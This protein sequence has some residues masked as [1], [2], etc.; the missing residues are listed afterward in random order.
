M[1]TLFILML[2]TIVIT[3]YLVKELE[4][5]PNSKNKDKTN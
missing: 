4:K 2:G 3:F 5:K 1:A